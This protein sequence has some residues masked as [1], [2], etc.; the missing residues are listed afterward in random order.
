MKLLKK[1]DIIK[2]LYLWWEEGIC[3]KSKD[4]EV[5]KNLTKVSRA[6]K[7]ALFWLVPS[8]LQEATSSLCRNGHEDGLQL[9]YSLLCV[10]CADNY[11]FPRCELLSLRGLNYMPS[12]GRVL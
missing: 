3:V 7:S 11:S 9:P 5:Q 6:A 8:L 12:L 1:S 2:V 4:S 10:S